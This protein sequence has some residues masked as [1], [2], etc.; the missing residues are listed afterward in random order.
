MER[1]HSIYQDRLVKELRLAEVNSI[2]A[3]NQFLQNDYCDQLNERFAVVPRSQV[4]S[5]A[6]LKDMT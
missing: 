6:Q 2:E 4:I 5:T 3:A 1:N